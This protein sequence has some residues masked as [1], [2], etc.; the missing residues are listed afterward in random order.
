MTTHVD[1]FIDDP[2]T[3]NYAAWIFNF[4][5]LPAALK[6]RFEPFMKGQHLFCTYEGRRY[7]VTG[8]SRLGDV[9]LARDFARDVGYDLRVEVTK[10]SSW[11]PTE[12]KTP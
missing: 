5:R 1:D 8:A 12:G 9:W 7:R 6:M 4:F 10:C 2:H 3:D 11:G